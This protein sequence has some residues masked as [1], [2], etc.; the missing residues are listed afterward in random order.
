MREIK[1]RG[2]RNDNNKWIYG[3]YGWSMGKHYIT[4]I[5]NESP[6]WQDPSGT[7]FEI[8][9]EVDSKSVSQFTGMQDKNGVDIYEGDIVSVFDIE[10][11]KG[12]VIFNEGS[13]RLKED[14]L[15]YAHLSAY[16]TKTMCEVIG[17]IY[18]HIQSYRK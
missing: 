9:K 14:L 10:E 11:T 16:N 12:E 5:V 4:E 2:N 17:N 3:Y 1:F 8:F 6:S 18:E 13:F 15:F 7:Y